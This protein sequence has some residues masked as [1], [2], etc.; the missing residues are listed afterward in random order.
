M[1]HDHEFTPSCP[2]RVVAY[3]AGEL[4]RQVWNPESGTRKLLERESDKAIRVW[5]A[6]YGPL[7]AAQCDY[8]W[9]LFE[10]AIRDAARSSRHSAVLR[11]AH[12]NQNFRRLYNDD[13]VHDGMKRRG[14]RVLLKVDTD[15]LM[16]AA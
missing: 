3:A 2:E 5:V 9:E 13:R 14:G 12:L 4:G 8:C 11:F 7:T 16:V 1:K 15:G 10:W 6:K